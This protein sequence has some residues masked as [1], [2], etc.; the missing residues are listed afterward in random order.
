MFWAHMGSLSPEAYPLFAILP[1]PIADWEQGA[2]LSSALCNSCGRVE[3]ATSCHTARRVQES[4]QEAR[5]LS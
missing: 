5:G 4:V 3:R 1:G 2:R